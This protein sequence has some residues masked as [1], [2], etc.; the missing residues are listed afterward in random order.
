MSMTF[1]RKITHG[2]AILALL[3]GCATSAKVTQVEDKEIKEVKVGETAKPVQFR[4]MAL[5]MPRNRVI[6]AVQAGLLCVPQ[7]ELTYRGGRVAI[8]DDQYN[9]VFREELETA[10]YVVVGDPDAL[11]DDPESWKAE[12]LIGGLIK[13][14]K[15]NIC[16]PMSG[17]GS[18]SSS[19]GEAEIEV[20]WQIYSR[21]NRKV[22]HEVKTKGSSKISSKEN[23]AEDI[24]LEAF[25]SASRQLLSDEGFYNLITGKSTGITA[26][27][28]IA[29]SDKASTV[30]ERVSNSKRSFL[31]QA[32]TIRGQVATVYAGDGTGSGFF[33]ADRYL[34]TNQ[35]VVGGA[36]FVKIK[37]VTGREILGE[38]IKTN[39]ARDVALIQTEPAGVLGLPIRTDELAIGSQ[40]Y[41]VGSPL[42]QKNE[43]TVTSGIVSSYRSEDG[44][45]IL[46]SDVSVQPGNSGGPMFDDKG[47]VIA[48]TVAGLTGD[49][50]TTS[51]GVNY[52]IPIVDALD[53]LAIQIKGPQS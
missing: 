4:K 45:R 53:K 52:F 15:A 19:S 31:E 41:V 24:F 11:F 30:I 3:T 35:H 43:G 28:A 25:A 42:G 14:I 13:D 34:I 36:R 21:L 51:L 37:F 44:M 20:E 47:N 23:G 8:D 5:R 22:V 32:T 10:N 29:S 16:F 18:F 46:Q 9:D 26:S 38:V 33:I 12:Y 50:R 17:F 40:V 6:G 1:F 7:G 27:E 39:S 2:S 48:I 49:G